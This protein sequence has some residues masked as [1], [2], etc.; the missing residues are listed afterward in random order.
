MDGKQHLSLDKFTGAS[1]MQNLSDALGKFGGAAKENKK[2]RKKGGDK[3]KE[4]KDGD[5]KKEKADMI[6][7]YSPVLPLVVA[8]CP[9]ISLPFLVQPNHQTGSA[10]GGSTIAAS[11]SADSGQPGVEGCQQLSDTLL[12][13]AL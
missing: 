3:N 8:N 11:K 6:C 10:G 4:Q 2:N 1:G 7:S 12:Q 13:K 9:F 5:D